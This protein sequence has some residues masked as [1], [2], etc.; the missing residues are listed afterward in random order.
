MTWTKWILVFIFIENG[1]PTATKLGEYKNMP[2]CF[3][4]RETV[5]GDL[6]A[7]EGIPPINTQI[8]GVKAE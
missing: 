8:V 6:E 2:T 1:E 5:V 3:E 4:A 7:Y